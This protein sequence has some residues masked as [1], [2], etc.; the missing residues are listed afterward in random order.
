[1]EGE[2][3]VYWMVGG[4]LSELLRYV[5]T[6]NRLILVYDGY[7]DVVLNRLRVRK[8]HIPCD[9]YIHREYPLLIHKQVPL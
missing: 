6:L 9:L 4:G 7:L 1:M 5:C 8:L 2:G 3:E